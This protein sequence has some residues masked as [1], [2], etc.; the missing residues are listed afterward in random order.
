MLP[1]TP[2]HAAWLGA[3]GEGLSL[4]GL[5]DIFGSCVPYSSIGHCGEVGRGSPHTKDLDVDLE[6]RETATAQG[7]CLTAPVTPPLAR[8]S[9][10]HT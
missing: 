8:C 5:R 6:G 7:L 9:P 3:V 1:G 2:A 10:T 4:L